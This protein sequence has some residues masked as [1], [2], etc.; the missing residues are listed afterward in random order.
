MTLLN[1]EKIIKIWLF[2]RVS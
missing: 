2:F 1:G